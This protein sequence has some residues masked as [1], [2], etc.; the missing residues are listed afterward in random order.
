MLR[1]L[2]KDHIILPIFNVHTH[3][4][5]GRHFDLKMAANLK[6]FIF[7]NSCFWN[8]IPYCSIKRLTCNFRFPMQTTLNEGFIR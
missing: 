4:L 6:L 8:S 2:L 7:H 1:F 3:W 5:K